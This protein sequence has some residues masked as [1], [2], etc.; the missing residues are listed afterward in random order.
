MDRQKDDEIYDNDKDTP[1]R[2]AKRTKFKQFDDYEEVTE[3][4]DKHS[5]KRSHRR[6]TGKED[7]WP[8]ADD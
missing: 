2:R 7:V 4:R 8:D 6:K 1:A 5:R 3:S